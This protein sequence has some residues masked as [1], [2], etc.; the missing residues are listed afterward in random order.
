MAVHNQKSDLA[1]VKFREHMILIFTLLTIAVSALAA[2]GVYAYCTEKNSDKLV[3]QTAALNRQIVTFVNYFCSTAERDCNEV[4]RSPEIIGY[5][6]VINDY[7]DYSSDAQKTDIK[8]FMLDMAAGKCYN[9]FFMFFSDGQ[10]VGKVSSG[11]TDFL[12]DH[13]FFDVY[14]FLGGK[15]DIWMLARSGTRKLYYLRRASDHSIFIMSCYVDELGSVMHLEGIDECK[16]Y[17]LDENDVVILSNDPSSGLRKQLPSEYSA[18]FRNP[19][20]ESCI[21]P[22]GLIGASIAAECG[23]RVVTVIQSQVLPDST[24][25]IF[26]SAFAVLALVLLCRIAGIIGAAGFVDPGNDP[27]SEYIDPL[28]LRYNEYGLD[29]KINE[30]FETSLV[31]SAFAFIMIGIKDEDAVR[32]AVSESCWN[33]ILVKLIDISEKFFSGQKIIAGRSHNDRI[34]VLTDCAAS[35]DPKAQDKLVQ[36]CNDFCRAFS[37]LTAGN[38]SALKLHVN[39]GV[40]I[41]PYH[42]EDFDSLFTKAG[43]ALEKAA[44][45][46]DDCYVIYDPKKFENEGGSK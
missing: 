17:L 26:I 24:G 29:E 5:D 28:T 23:W 16:C 14:D 1:L 7:P 31:G 8:N 45:N 25:L 27:E 4:F 33:E 2:V 18:L 32:A 36:G 44:E 34:I 15:P 39:I 13:D 35:D 11:A 38:D 19:A 43:R 40:S 42:A 12:S 21:S 46:D 30:Q 6:P 41:Y 3:K 37:G 20:G 9:D 10:T 22:D